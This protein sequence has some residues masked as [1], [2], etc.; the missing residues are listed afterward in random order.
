MIYDAIRATS[1]DRPFAFQSLE[2]LRLDVATWRAQNA[3]LR[4]LR[5]ASS[6]VQTAFLGRSVE[7]LKHESAD[8]G[9]FRVV[10]TLFDAILHAINTA[11][12]PL[13]AELTLRL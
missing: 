10:S 7:W 12:K 6:D 9:N 5:K 2:Q 13:P 3:A 4:A 1:G 11:P 8:H